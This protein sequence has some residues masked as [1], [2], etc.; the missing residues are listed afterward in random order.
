M[1]IFY[2]AVEFDR[3]Y[4][5]IRKK[6]VLQA[7]VNLLISFFLP[8][9]YTFARLPTILSFTQFSGTIILMPVIIFFFLS[10]F[11]FISLSEKFKRTALRIAVSIN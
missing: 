7:A 1:K 8:E 2:G 5:S 6:K 10:Q 9:C 11:S 3:K 4:I